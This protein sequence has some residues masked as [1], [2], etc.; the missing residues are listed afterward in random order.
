MP[1]NDIMITPE[2]G[3]VEQLGS[4]QFLI[5]ELIDKECRHRPLQRFTYRPV[6]VP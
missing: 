6:S 2:L 4:V 3:W 1:N 5:K